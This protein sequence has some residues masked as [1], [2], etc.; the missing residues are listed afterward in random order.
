MQILKSNEPFVSFQV[1]TINS[2]ITSFYD[3]QMYRF[4]R[5]HKRRKCNWR[6]RWGIVFKWPAFELANVQP[7]ENWD[8]V[9]SIKSSIG[10]DIDI[11]RL[12]LLG[13][14]RVVMVYLKF[15]S[16]NIINN[17]GRKV[18]KIV[19]KMIDRQILYSLLIYYLYDTD[20][21]QIMLVK[22]KRSYR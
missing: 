14:T 16:N 19:T 1:L 7:F 2:T 21:S 11:L 8:W 3:L 17:Y 10:I 9:W 5:R 22:W 18:K 6:Y 13:Y 15:N 20:S 12:W 4:N